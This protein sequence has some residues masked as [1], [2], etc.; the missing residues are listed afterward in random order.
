M[1]LAIGAALCLLLADIRQYWGLEISPLTASTMLVAIAASL[2]VSLISLRV[3]LLT[4]F[5][6]LISEIY[7]SALLGASV[8]NAFDL[9]VMRSLML[10]LIATA[11]LAWRAALIRGKHRR[12]QLGLA[13][14]TGLMPFIVSACV[15]VMAF[16][17][18][19][20]AARFDEAFG[21]YHDD[22]GFM[23]ARF[24]VQS[25]FVVVILPLTMTVLDRFRIV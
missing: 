19:A 1:I 21:A 20:T 23:A 16:A 13:V 14:A 4:L 15:V 8:V 22:L 12:E 17:A 2:I 10:T 11:G 6:F 25:V 9:I 5:T 7:V 18:F 24:A 3:T